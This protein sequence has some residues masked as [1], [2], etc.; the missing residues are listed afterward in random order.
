MN[1]LKPLK[2]RKGWNEKGVHVELVLD[3]EPVEAPERVLIAR[4]EHEEQRQLPGHSGRGRGLLHQDS[5]QRH[6]PGQGTQGGWQGKDSRPSP[7]LNVLI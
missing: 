3:H 6:Q 2:F 1:I 4:E 5:S 7:S